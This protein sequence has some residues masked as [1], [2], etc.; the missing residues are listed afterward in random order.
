MT[1]PYARASIGVLSISSVVSLVTMTIGFV[2][3]VTG[4]AG[5]LHS[6]MIRLHL[7]IVKENPDVARK[8]GQVGG[9]L[10]AQSNK[11]S[12]LLGS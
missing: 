4:L 5:T 7:R 1:S 12:N 11:L 8:W 6:F 3:I 10:S 9:K 2:C